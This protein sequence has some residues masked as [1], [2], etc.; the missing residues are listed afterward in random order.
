MS[1]LAIVALA[2]VWILAALAL[3]WFVGR[4]ASL[5]DYRM[6]EACRTDLERRRADREALDEAMVAE[7][8][9]PLVAPLD[10]KKRARAGGAAGH[11]TG[12]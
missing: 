10:V 5:G 4:M 12:R 7:N 6:R 1:A 2:A 9:R 8:S 11:T 3:A